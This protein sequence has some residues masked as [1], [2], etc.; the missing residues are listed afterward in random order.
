[1]DADAPERRIKEPDAE[2]QRLLDEEEY[3]EG[4]WQARQELALELEREL[5]DAIYRW[6]LDSPLS[7]GLIDDEF[8][9]I[10]IAGCTVRV[11]YDARL[12]DGHRISGG[13]VGE[14]PRVEEGGDA[15]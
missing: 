11:R 3:L 15:A 12:E 10:A 6:F 7:R 1:M 9:R 13:F 4:M 2:L 8:S 14:E 5:R